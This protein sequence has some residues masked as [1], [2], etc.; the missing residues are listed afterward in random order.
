MRKLIM[1]LI[2]LEVLIVYEKVWLAT[3]YSNI[4]SIS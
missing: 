4:N 2:I 1:D 3:K